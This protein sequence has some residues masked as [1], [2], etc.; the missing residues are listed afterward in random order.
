[1]SGAVTT[2]PE[3][4]I[5]GADLSGSNHCFLKATADQTVAAATLHSDAV[6]GVQD[7]VPES[8]TGSQVNVR[9]IGTVEIVASAA[10]S[11]GAFLKPT[12]GGKAVTAS[13]GNNY[14]AIA[15]GVATADGDIIE[16]VLKTGVTP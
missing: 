7:D 14:H 12:T 3:T 9:M 2:S 11:A 16:C 6:V 8:A 10:I 15:L 4:F 13:S 5:S 1:M